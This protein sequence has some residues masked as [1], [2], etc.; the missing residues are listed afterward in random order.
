MMSDLPKHVYA[1]RDRHGKIRYRFNR[2]GWKSAYIHGTPG[3]AEFHRAYA[4][5][6]ETGALKRDPIKSLRTVKERSIED[7]YQRLR[8]STRWR[9]KSPRTQL[10][11]G[12]ILDRFMD[13]VSKQGNRYGDRPIANV[14]V[15][16]LDTILGL[17]WETPAAANVLRKNLSGVMDY[18]IKLGWRTDNPVRLTDSYPEGEGHH[19]WTDAEIEQ[20]RAKHPLG[21][22]ARLTLELALN[23]AARRCNVNKIERDHIV[24]GLIEVAHVKGNDET[25]VPMLAT[26]KAALDALPATPF[27][28]LV[29]TQFGKPFTDA[30]LGNRMRKWCDEAGLPQCSMHGLRK[31]MSRQ[32]AESGA[33]DA[34][35]Q[36]VTGHKKDETF[37]YY[38]AKA[39][40]KKLAARA[41]ANLGSLAGF[42]PTEN[43]EETDV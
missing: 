42:Q 34:E 35:G 28:F 40:R 13:T 6:L 1:V 25:A 4:E 23:T 3:S 37:A 16:W 26:T 30:G 27:K 22:M 39:N 18:A 31:A 33:T 9:K 24:A 38:R 12:R 5:I 19:D 29:T 17:M 21:T 8:V 10:V 14:T 36:A 20:Y 43:D 15:G 32:L 41:V 7:A 2:K 11:Q